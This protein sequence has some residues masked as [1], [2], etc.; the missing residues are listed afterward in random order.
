MVVPDDW[1]A[2]PGLHPFWAKVLLRGTLIFFGT[3]AVTLA[4]LWFMFV[5]APGPDEVCERLSEL[6]VED[7]RAHGSDVEAAK[8]LLDRIAKSCVEDKGRIIQLRG[9]IEYAKYAKC[10]MAAESLDVAER[11]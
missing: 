1:P 4:V 5:A 10:V 7:T 2:E 11:C 6:T 8:P 3:L 9:K